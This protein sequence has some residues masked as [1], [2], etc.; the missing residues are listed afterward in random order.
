MPV[1]GSPRSGSRPNRGTP[2]ERGAEFAAEQ[3][4][5]KREAAERREARE[6][7]AEKAP[8][9]RRGRPA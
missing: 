9:Q 8:K 2:A 3:A 7:M 6:A 5:L 4:R 1:G